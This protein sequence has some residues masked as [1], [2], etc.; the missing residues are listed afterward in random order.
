VNAQ[1]KPL[2]EVPEEDTRTKSWKTVSGDKE[3]HKES[4]GNDETDG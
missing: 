3:Q 4:E 2:E 1:A